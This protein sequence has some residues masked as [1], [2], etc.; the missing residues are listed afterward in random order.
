M[1]SWFPQSPVTSDAPNVAKKAPLPDQN[2]LNEPAHAEE[3]TPHDRILGNLFHTQES[4]EKRNG[5]LP[6]ASGLDTNNAV[7][8]PFDGS[9]LGSLLAPDHN[10]QPE[11]P[12]KLSDVAAKN[13]ELWSHLSRV[14]ELQNQISSLHLDLEGIGLNAGDPKGKGKGTRSRATSVSRVVIDDVEGDEGIG[15]KRDEEAE[16]N[17]AREEQF[18]NLHGQFRGKKEAIDGIMMKLDSLSKAVTE[19]HALQAPKIDF[20]S[21]RHDSLPVTNT[22]ATSEDQM[23][24]QFNPGPI[25]PSLTP[26][27][28]NI[29][30]R[31]VEPG[32]PVLVDSPMSG[33]MPLPP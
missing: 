22:A 30:R 1:L 14:L 17:K 25:K 10:I 33:I 31:A 12:G 24:A 29:L 20:T 7:Y 18:S 9:F 11:E 28:V 26:G 21:S 2:G 32:T 8:D 19:F 4:S 16:R 23:H 3:V 27:P 15:G 13:E 6:H 5:S